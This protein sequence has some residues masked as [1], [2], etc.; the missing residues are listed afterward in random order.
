MKLSLSSVAPLLLPFL[1]GAV[2]QTNSTTKTNT[3]TTA[4]NLTSPRTLVTGQLWIRAVAAPNYHKYLQTKP[5]LTASTA[6]LGSHT[7][8]GQYN[9]VSGQL[10][11]YNPG[12]K[13]LYLWVEK[14]ADP[15]KP[16]RTLATAFNTTENPYGKFVFQGDAVTWSAE[17]LQRQNLAAWLVCNSTQLYINTGAYAYQ[18]PSGCA[19]QTVR[20]LILT[21]LTPQ[22]GPLPL[23]ITLLTALC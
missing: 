16:P 5:E 17:G 6:I 1:S 22:R 19:D 15:A 20:S 9:I 12:G 11:A 23:A 13:P 4:T 8:A 21:T 18:T 7:T 2:A 10:V 3:T 14:P